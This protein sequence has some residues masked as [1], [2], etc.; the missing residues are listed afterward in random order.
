MKGLRTL[1]QSGAS[2]V[3]VGYCQKQK[4][5]QCSSVKGLL[6]CDSGRSKL[7]SLGCCTFLTGRGQTPGKM[8]G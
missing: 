3:F 6:E 5:V 1:M 2:L 7:H 4:P 8:P